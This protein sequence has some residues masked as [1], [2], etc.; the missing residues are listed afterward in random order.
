MRCPKCKTISLKEGK[1][2]DSSVK[3]DYCTKCRGI[4]FDF[5]EFEQVTENAIKELKIHPDADRHSVYCPRCIQP[6][7]TF[8]YPQTYAKIDMCQKCRG[9]WLDAGEL[10]E[11]GTVRRGLAEA[12]KIQEYDRVPGV[13]G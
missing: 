1:V 8:R 4:W 2:K 3:I 9:L 5:G 6:L 7:H 11:I 12:G 10:K 13:K